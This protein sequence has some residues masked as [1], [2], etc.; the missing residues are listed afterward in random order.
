MS[1]INKGTV[2][3]TGPKITGSKDFYVSLY[4]GIEYLEKEKAWGV[5]EPHGFIQYTLVL[6]LPTEVVGTAVLSA[7]P[8]VGKPNS[9]F[10]IVVNGLVFVPKFEVSNRKAKPYE[11]KVPADFFFKGENTIITPLLP[12]STTTVLVEKVSTE[13]V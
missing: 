10:S 4:H 11:W 9:F 2:D 5:V 8:L 7:V 12:D 1:A 13:W 3:F 6:D